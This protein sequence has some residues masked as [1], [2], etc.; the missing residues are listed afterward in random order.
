[1]SLLYEINPLTIIPCLLQGYSERRASIVFGDKAPIRQSCEP[2]ELQYWKTQTRPFQGTPGLAIY[3]L[4]DTLELHL[5]ET[6]QS[7]CE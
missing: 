1:M 3:K 4:H 2:S 5:Y 6:I 7:Q